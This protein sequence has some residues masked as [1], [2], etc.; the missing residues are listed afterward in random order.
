M[1]KVNYGETPSK[2]EFLDNIDEFLARNEP[3]TRFFKRDPNYIQD[4]AKKATEL[5]DDPLVQGD[6]LPKMIGVTLR[7]QVI[8]CGMSF[9]PCLVQF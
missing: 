1:Q 2:A 7:Q 9:N 4:L 3:L 5:V 6:Q 8:Y